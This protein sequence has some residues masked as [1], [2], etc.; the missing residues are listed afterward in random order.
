MHEIECLSLSD[1][2]LGMEAYAIKKTLERED[3]ALQAWMN[4]TV[5]ATKGSDKHPQPMYKK[6]EDF[7]DANELEDNIRG[8]FEPDYVSKHAIEKNEQDEIRS[9]WDAIQKMR[10][11][12]NK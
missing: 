2:W 1:Y 8:E 5:Q 6:F 4:Q 12:R 10:E 7:Y 9:R 3:L 11:R